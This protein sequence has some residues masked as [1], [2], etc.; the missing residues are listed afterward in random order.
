MLPVGRA[1][2]MLRAIAFTYGI[3]GSLRS[4]EVLKVDL[5]FAWK[6]KTAEFRIGFGKERER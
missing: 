6:S 4:V 5:G 1:S 2:V 3:S